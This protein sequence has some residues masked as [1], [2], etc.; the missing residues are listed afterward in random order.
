MIEQLI[1][2]ILFQIDVARQEC[3]FTK[4]KSFG[5]PAGESY[6]AF[7]GV[8]K[9]LIVVQF[10]TFLANTLWQNFPVAEKGAHDR[11]NGF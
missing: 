8:V 9:T 10:C 7:A 4:L 2:Q 11:C 3:V 6:K 1:A 5:V